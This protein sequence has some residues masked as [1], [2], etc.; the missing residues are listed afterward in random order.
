MPEEGFAC[1]EDRREDLL[2]WR[3]GADSIVLSSLM[4]T[5]SSGMESLAVRGVMCLW[6]GGKA[7]VAA[8]VV[9]VVAAAAASIELGKG[10][11]TEA[12]ACGA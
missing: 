1:R 11:G 4:S 7:R 10:H 3:E 9:V 6:S 8:V 5:A 12:M 2:E